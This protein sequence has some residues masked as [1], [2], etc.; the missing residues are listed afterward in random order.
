MEQVTNSGVV[1]QHVQLTGN[2]VAG[3][4]I[5][6]TETKVFRS[7]PEFSQINL[8]PYNRKNYLSPKFTYQVLESIK[9]KRLILVGGQLWI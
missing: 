9:K 3:R 7:K 8:T 1:G 5:L 6:I 2:Y 4:D